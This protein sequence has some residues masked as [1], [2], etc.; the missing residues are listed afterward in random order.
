MRDL[1]RDPSCNLDDCA[2]VVFVSPSFVPMSIANRYWDRGRARD[3]QLNRAAY[4]F[5]ES[6][7]IRPRSVMGINSF[8]SGY[9][10]A[11]ALVK[12][13]LMPTLSLSE[14]EFVLVV[15][16]SR[17]SRITDFSC[18][19][20]GALFGDF[21]TATILSRCDSYRYPVSFEV[22]D[23]TFNKRQVPRP[24]FDF[25]MREDVLVPTPDG[26]RSHEP[27]RLVFSLDGMGIADIAPRGM[28]ASA[29]K[30]MES[31]RLSP[32]QVRHVVP[33][34]A[35]DGILRLAGMKLEDA[36]LTVDVVNGMAKDIG[37]V[38]SC[39]VPS[40]IKNLWHE[41]KGNILCPVAAVGAPGKCEVSEG[42]ILLHATSPQQSAAA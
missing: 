20:S 38:S 17:I 23:A 1:V 5:T 11:L 42:C 26:G 4:R 13:K 40:A 30:I 18:K 22:I 21:A 2:A 25:S 28:A 6:L 15:T 33:H 36:G 10:R 37:N 16:A 34:Q 27:Q 19:Q 12:N 24:M 41:L 39:S 31:N 7:E 29:A 9:A 32:D 35:G 14:T 8:C 3:E